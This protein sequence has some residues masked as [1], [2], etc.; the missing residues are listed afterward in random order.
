MKIM[1]T[2]LSLV[3]RC[4]RVKEIRTHESTPCVWFQ[5]GTNRLLK[6]E[7]P[8]SIHVFFF[9]K[10]TLILVGPHAEVCQRTR[11]LEQLHPQNVY[12]GKGVV[13]SNTTVRRKAGKKAWST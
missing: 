4:Y 8:S 3:G 5:L 2:Q 13:Q 10:N 12:T 9:E 6:W 7:V 11:S 1:Y